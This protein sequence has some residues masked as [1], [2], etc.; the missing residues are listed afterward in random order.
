MP[1]L[2]SDWAGSALLIERLYTDN[3]SGKVPDE[4]DLKMSAKFE[5]EQAELPHAG[6][7]N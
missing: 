6:S 1:S 7:Q 5:A 2:I 4:R 3:I